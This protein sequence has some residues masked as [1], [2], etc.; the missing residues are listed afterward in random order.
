MRSMGAAL[1]RAQVLGIVALL[2]AVEDLAADTEVAT[3]EGHVVAA[4]V[5]VHPLQAGAGLAAQ[6][7]PRARQLARTGKFSITNLHFDTL[8]SV[9]NHYERTQ[10][11]LKVGDLE[12]C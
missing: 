8:S 10:Y 1:Q 12:G 9:N 4:A 3:G 6:L 2:P 5:I 7:F 11:H